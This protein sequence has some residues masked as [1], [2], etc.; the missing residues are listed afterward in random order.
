MVSA[1][2]L[3][4]EQQISPLSADCR[5]QGHS[6]IP[7]FITYSSSSI[8]EWQLNRPGRTHR[9]ST[10]EGKMASSD[11]DQS[12]NRPTDPMQ[13]CTEYSMTGALPARDASEK[14]MPPSPYESM[15]CN[16]PHENRDVSFD[17]I[18]KL[19]SDNPSNTYPLG[20]RHRSVSPPRRP[21]GMSPDPDAQSIST[22]SVYSQPEYASQ[23]T[24]FDAENSS[25]ATTSTDSHPPNTSSITSP[26][27]ST[28]LSHGTSTS[29]PQLLSPSTPLANRSR[30]NPKLARLKSHA[31]Q[32]AKIAARTAELAPSAAEMATAARE[33]QERVEKLRVLHEKKSVAHLANDARL[34][35]ERYGGGGLAGKGKT[36]EEEMEEGNVERNHQINE[37]RHNRKKREAPGL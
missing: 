33:H 15:A 29:H 13:H 35:R 8:E 31:S 4:G 12:Q 2:R 14:S 36:K 19:P 27:H 24:S 37:P 32:T 30:V 16:P 1:D 25:R 20:D 22:G 5:R 23:A 7:F 10:R 6:L 9:H 17:D 11:P 26:A 3:G 18:A 28:I 21:C 34:G